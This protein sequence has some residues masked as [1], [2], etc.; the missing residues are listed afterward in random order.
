MNPPTQELVKPTI[1][2]LQAYDPHKRPGHVK[3][4]ANEFPYPLPAAVRE[5]VLQ[6]LAEV[7]VNR[8]P[9]PEAERLRQAI[10]RWIGV[11][12]AMMLLGNGS[13]EVIQM[14][15]M[16]CGR[17]NGVVLTPAPTFPM[18]RIAAQVLDQ[19]PIEV[20]L[21]PDWSLDLPSMRQTMEHQ[22]PAVTFIATPNNPTANRFDDA[23]VRALIDAAPGI[24]A[25]DEAYHPFSGQ[26]FL[27]LLERNSHLVI[28]RTFSK[29]G[30]AGLRVGILL[31]NAELIAQINKVRAP[32]NVNAYS[33]T[34]A[35]V[36]LAHWA[37]IAPQI[38]E[39]LRERRR[40]CDRL[41]SLPGVTVYPSDANFLLVRFAMG[42]SKVW[43]ALGERGILVRSYGDAYGLQ[44]CLRITVGTP[45]E[46]DLLLEALQAI[47]AEMQPLLRT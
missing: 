43:K 4:D 25:I 35:E 10:G 38:Q 9:D 28:L 39:I 37:S 17:P 3:L 1:A 18:Y 33:Q 12:P 22:R 29:I 24:I 27:P 14:L 34:A 19:R 45:P 46:N 5:A 26:T 13:D 23:A 6:A 7:D 30:L 36:V 11:D 31:A 42:G 41:A 20:P 2:Q 40:L 16:A 21:T 47:T 8:Y 44:N 32:Y 15:L